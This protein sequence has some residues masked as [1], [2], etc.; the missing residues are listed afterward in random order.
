MWL[1]D[2]A[3]A[4]AGIRIREA[5]HRPIAEE[6]ARCLKA[7]TGAVFNIQS[8]IQSTQTAG[9]A[10]TIALS[11][12]PKLLKRYAS[13]KSRPREAVAWTCDGKS[14]L[15]ITGSS[16]DALWL[17]IYAFLEQHVDCRWFFPGPDGE[18]I[19][20][21]SRLQV[22]QLD[23]HLTPSFI[24]RDWRHWS[25]SFQRQKLGGGFTFCRAHSYGVMVPEDVLKAHPEYAVEIGGERLVDARLQRCLSQQGVEDCAVQYCLDYFEKNPDAPVIGLSPN[26]GETFCDCRPCVQANLGRKPRSGE[27]GRS[28]WCVTRSVFGFSNRVAKRVAK[29]HP[30]KLIVVIAY[31]R[32]KQP[33]KGLK[34]HDNILVW[35]CDEPRFNW[36]GESGRQMMEDEIA[37]WGQSARQLGIFDYVVNR[38]WPGLIRPLTEIL[39]RE[40]KQLHR[41]GGRYYFT[42]HADDFGVNLPNYYLVASLLWNIDQ[43]PDAVLRDMYD[44]CFRKAGRDVQQF[45]NVLE[46]AVSRAAAGGSGPGAIGITGHR[47]SHECVCAIYTPEVLRDAERALKQAASK[48]KGDRVVMRRLKIVR[49]A[50]AMLSAAVH[51]ARLTFEFEM[52]YRIPTLTP[53]AWNVGNY[54]YH[55]AVEKFE[56][57]G[58][59]CED[60]FREVLGAWRDFRALRERLEPTP[61]IASKDAWYARPGA[62]FDATDTLQNIWDLYTGKLKKVPQ[63]VTAKSVLRAM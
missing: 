21:R 4:K 22:P 34:V 25:Q 59:P 50:F 1:A 18:D 61:A 9:D 45:Y 5:S 8:T 28:P 49:D 56:L 10:A 62:S 19:P 40:L 32:T 57:F 42:Q 63:L 43:D 6:L 29:V 15:E 58:K 44:R 3:R 7:A 24:V 27:Q 51:A 53:W 38:S 35:Y 17:A 30:D 60:Q 14:R 39:A 11:V 12:S 46:Q 20:R 23:T 26:D 37:G 31:S 13:R 48:A 52:R 41:H 55:S 33:V 47:R 36:Q 2:K 16:V 54:D